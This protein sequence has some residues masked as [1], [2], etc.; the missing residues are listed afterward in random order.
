VSWTDTVGETLKSFG[1]AN[2]Y[3]K[4]RT[5][6]PFKAVSGT[7]YDVAITFRDDAT[8][9][10]TGLVAYTVGTPSAPVIDELDPSEG[11]AGSV[12]HI[13]GENLLVVGSKPVVELEKDGVKTEAHL[14]FLKPGFFHGSEE[15]VV[16]VPLDTED[17]D[18]DVTVTV[19][20]QV[21]N[22]A[23][24]TVG[25]RPLAV[26]SMKPN[27]Q[28]SKGTF[29]PV[30]IQGSGFGLPGPDSRS[31]TVLWDNGVDAAR[32]GKVIFRVDQLILVIPPG[33][34]FNPL[35]SG[36]YDVSVVLGPASPSG[37]EESVSAGTYTVK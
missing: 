28:G 17:G 15:L 5:R 1:F 21:S 25:E 30:R 31:L 34:R 16:G 18:Y 2:G 12:F 22:A 29:H 33:G 26:D 6:V 23:T 13:R 7:T 27:S 9:E 35:D 3:D 8:T 19:G 24:F 14:L 4:V 10:D 20:A 32:E 11:P 36:E 37:P